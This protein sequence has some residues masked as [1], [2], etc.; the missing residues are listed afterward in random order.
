ME[1]E[2]AAAA[3]IIKC[4]MGDLIIRIEEVIENGKT[5][6]IID[7]SEDRK[8]ATFFNYKGTC[9]YIEYYCVVEFQAGETWSILLEIILRVPTASSYSNIYIILCYCTGTLLNAKGMVSGI[10]SGMTKRESL[11]MSRKMVVQVSLRLE[12]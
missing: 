9:N 10:L 11:E 7:T 6:L 1:A 8:V 3:G 2:L 12:W 5:P 4:K